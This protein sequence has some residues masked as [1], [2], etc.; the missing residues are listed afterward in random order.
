MQN[1]LE[2]A[3]KHGV[4]R[5]TKAFFGFGPKGAVLAEMVGPFVLFGAQLEGPEILT[6]LRGDARGRRTMR[7]LADRYRS[8]AEPAFKVVAGET[9]VPPLLATASDVDFQGGWVLGAALFQYPL[10]PCQ[11]EPPTLLIPTTGTRLPPEIRLL[12]GDTALALLLPKESLPPRPWA[13][14][15]ESLRQ[16]A[17]QAVGTSATLVARLGPGILVAQLTPLLRR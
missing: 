13:S 14:L 3:V 1:V 6:S 2:L 9:G 12:R 15:R 17:K 8:F 4:M 7:D 11:E 10:R 16:E 5:S